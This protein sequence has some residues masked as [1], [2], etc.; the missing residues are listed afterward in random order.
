MATFVRDYGFSVVENF[1][2]HGIGKNMHEDPQVPNFCSPSF[3]RKHDFE[4]EPGLVIAVEPMVN[5]GTKKS[6][7]TSG[8]LDSINGRWEVQCSF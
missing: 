5:M 6:T 1:V 2:G 7:A 4:L 8:F 3:R